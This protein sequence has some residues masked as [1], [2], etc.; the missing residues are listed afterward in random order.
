MSREIEKRIADRSACQHGVITRRQL[1]EAGLSPSAVDRRLMSGRY[2][3]IHSGVYLILPFPVQ[4]TRE[5]AAV[6]ASGRGAVV[7]HVSAAPLWGLRAIAEGPVDVIAPG[8]CGRRK[9]IR[10]HRVRLPEG[11]RTVRYRVPVTTPAR[12]LL[13]LA[14]VLEARELE[15]VVARAEREALVR[16]DELA[17]LVE[18]HAGQRGARA[19]RRVFQLPGAPALTRSAAEAELLALVRE[20]GLPPPECNVSIGRYEIDFIWRKARLAVE[21]DGFRYHS[22]RPRFE[23]D[24][25]KD[26]ELV[27]TGLTVLHLSWRQVAE[28]AMATAVRLGLTLAPRPGTTIARRPGPLRL[29]QVPTT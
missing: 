7:S 20:A 3:A 28:Q 15:G 1:L 17:K 2:H 21:V 13:D 5:M 24:R 27:A 4:H 8:N 6:L 9:G 29:T 23:G 11:E 18:R 19:I 10:V 22:S 16:P 14:S 26:A 12:T 25:R